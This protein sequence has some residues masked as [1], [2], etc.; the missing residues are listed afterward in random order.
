MAGYWPSSILHFSGPRR[1]QENAKKEQDNIILLY[2]QK[3]TPKNF[4]LREQ[5]RQSRAGNMGPSCP[6]G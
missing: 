6:L 5:S 2:G 1:L 3:I 4:P